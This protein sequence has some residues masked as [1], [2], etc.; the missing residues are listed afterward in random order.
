MQDVKDARRKLNCTEAALA[1]E[2]MIRQEA[3]MEVGESYEQIVK[4]EA[5]EAE[6]RKWKEKEPMINH[7]LGVLPKMAR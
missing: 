7:Y 6:L 4:L 5:K 2:K 1:E 3:S